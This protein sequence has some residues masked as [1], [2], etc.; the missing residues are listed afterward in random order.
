MKMWVT[1]CMAFFLSACLSGCVTTAI[2]NDVP[3]CE[4]LVPGILLAQVEGVAIPIPESWVDGH[5]KAEPW[6]L[7]YIEQTGQLDKS[8]DN[9]AAVDH[10]YRTCL[11]LHREALAK[12]K[13][14]F[15]GRLFS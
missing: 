6:M 1:L 3:R 15:F 4:R 10:I 2:T 7:G 9:T 13:R 12:S 14:S 8:N 11:E 5:E